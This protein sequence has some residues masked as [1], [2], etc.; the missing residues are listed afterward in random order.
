MRHTSALAHTLCFSKHIGVHTIL[1]IFQH[2]D[3]LFPSQY[4]SKFVQNSL[5]HLL[6]T[7]FQINEF[8]IVFRTFA[9]IKPLS[10][11]KVGEIIQA[12]EQNKFRIMQMKMVQLTKE[13]VSSAFENVKEDP[14]IQY[15]TN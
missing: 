2:Q 6:T 1:D 12:I 3:S 5:I 11:I 10:S 7:V 4:E 14:D 13:T 15:V 9:M 8:V